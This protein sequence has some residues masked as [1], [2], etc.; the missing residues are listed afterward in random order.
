[1]PL[2]DVLAGDGHQQG[3]EPR[4]GATENP[5]LL[6]RSVQNGRTKVTSGG[7]PVYIWPGGGITYMVDIAGLPAGAFGSVPTPAL[8]GASRGQLGNVH[9]FA[10]L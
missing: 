8:V 10:G 1:M 5:V 4:A 7:A 9:R 6:T 2:H 3:A